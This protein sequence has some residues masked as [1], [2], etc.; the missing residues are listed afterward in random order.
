MG[1]FTSN[2]VNGASLGVTSYIKGVNSSIH[3]YP[4]LI[5]VNCIRVDV[6]REFFLMLCISIS[7]LVLSFC[8]FSEVLLQPQ[9]S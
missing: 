7:L 6:P 3:L 2:T 8:H 9:F 5:M 4:Q 1:V